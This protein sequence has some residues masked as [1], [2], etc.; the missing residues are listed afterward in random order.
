VERNTRAALMDFPCLRDRPEYTASRIVILSGQ[1]TPLARK[2]QSGKL[3]YKIKGHFDEI[4][5]PGQPHN[6]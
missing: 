3:H 4:I 1:P 6:Q 5:C 2:D